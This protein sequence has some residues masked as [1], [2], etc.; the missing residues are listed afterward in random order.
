MKKTKPKRLEQTMLS[1][2]KQYNGSVT[3][4]QADEFIKLKRSLPAL[5]K[6]PFYKRNRKG[7]LCEIIGIKG[8]VKTI[9]VAKHGDVIYFDGNRLGKAKMTIVNGIFGGEIPKGFSPTKVWNKI[10]KQS[11]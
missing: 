9:G 4:Q 2:L 5:N 1:K 3:M 11:V 6:K 8:T 10:G 7:V